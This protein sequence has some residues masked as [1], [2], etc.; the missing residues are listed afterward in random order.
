VRLPFGKYR[1]EDIEDVPLSYL[2]WLLE[3]TRLTPD[4]RAAIL[5]EVARR[6]GLEVPRQEPPQAAIVPAELRR[7]AAEIVESGFRQAARRH[8]PDLGGSEHAMRALLEA[9]EC[10]RAWLN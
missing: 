4:L 10:L 5:E 1:G 3:E 2:A 6:L 8:H 9:R 7:W